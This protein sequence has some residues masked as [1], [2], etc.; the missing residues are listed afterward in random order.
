VFFLLLCQIL[1]AGIVHVPVA[2][3]AQLPPAASSHC[4]D[5]AV[6]SKHADGRASTLASHAT[7]GAT[8][9]ASDS[10]HHCKAGFCACV[11]LSAP[12]A[13]PET[14]AAGS[15]LISRPPLLMI[16]RIAV[17]PERAAVFFR[18]PI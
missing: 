8:H 18:P 11:C 7:S 1:A 12:A 13:L 16:D 2:K 6:G 4:H 17:A 14:S 5:G 10:T 9:P 3:A 15:A